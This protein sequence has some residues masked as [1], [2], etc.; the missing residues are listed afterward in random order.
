MEIATYD[1]MIRFN[2]TLVDDTLGIIQPYLPALRG[3][4]SPTFV[5]HRRWPGQGLLP[6]FEAV[7]SSLWST[8]KP[9]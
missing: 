5:L 6:A 1:D 8:S 4:D 3:M 9:L 2:I 7:F